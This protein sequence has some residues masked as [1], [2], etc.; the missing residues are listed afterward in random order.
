[1][2]FNQASYALLGV[3]FVCAS[4]QVFAGALDGLQPAEQSTVI[5]ALKTAGKASTPIRVT[6][7]GSLW[8]EFKVFEKIEATPEEAAAVFTDFA[9]HAKFFNHLGMEKSD[10]ISGKGTSTQLVAYSL[11][12]PLASDDYTCSDHIS[13][14]P[15]AGTYT[16]T[17]DVM[18][19]NRTY[20]KQ[21]AN[22]KPWSKGSAVFEPYEGGTLIAY[23]NLVSPKDAIGVTWR[24]VI[25]RGEST[26]VSTVETL[27]DQIK[28]EL[29]TA[30]LETQKENLKTALAH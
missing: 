24:W 12:I 16:V 10:V 8:P 4:Q 19:S 25:D 3:V 27:V 22:G 26:V 29:G 28:N 5:A 20:S 21:D 13:A 2:K 18:Q 14:D 17:W 1:M 23:T 15:A 6:V 7:G 30:E 11:N 9:N